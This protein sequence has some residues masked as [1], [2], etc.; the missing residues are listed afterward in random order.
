MPHPLSHGVFRGR[1]WGVFDKCS[2][3]KIFMVQGRLE[4]Q[5]ENADVCIPLVPA[6]T[7]LGSTAALLCA[8]VSLSVKLGC[9]PGSLKHLPMDGLKHVREAL[10]APA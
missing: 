2:S 9:C 4:I 10:N 6:L 1:G 3:V 7:P 8:S 5:F